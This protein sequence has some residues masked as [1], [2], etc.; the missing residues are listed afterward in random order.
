MP[1]KKSIPNAIISWISDSPGKLIVYF[2]ASLFIF[3][4]IGIIVLANK[5][6]L[7]KETFGR[8]IGNTFLHLISASGVGA[9]LTLLLAKYNHQH[10]KF[11]IDEQ[12]A[13]TQS[14]QLQELNRISNENKNQF[15][16]NIL[17]DLNETY[18]GFKSAR[19]MLRAKAFK[20]SYEDVIKNNSAIIDTKIYD[21]YLEKINDY[22]LRLETIL[23]ELDTNTNIFKNYSQIKTSINQMQEYLHGL[24]QE[25]ENYRFK[26]NA[27]S[28]SLTIEPFDKIK[29]LVDHAKK[30]GPLKIKFIYPYKKAIAAVR[31]ELLDGNKINL[32]IEQNKAT[33]RL[34]FDEVCNQGKWEI[35]NEIFA[36]QV[37]FNGKSG[38]PGIVIK[39]LQEIKD[40]FTN[41]KVK[42]NKQVAE[43]DRVSTMRTWTGIQSKEYN[44]S[45]PTNQL[46]TWMEISVVRLENGKIVE[47]WVVRSELTVASDDEKV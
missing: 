36:E 1:I 38:A 12:R 13:Y 30:N 26:A 21:H 14:I 42:V 47:D 15:V 11:K 2:L 8:E 19:R 27:D 24:V 9:I 37:N 45:P 44:N 16:K 35:I 22:Q 25:Y 43:E 33:V 34:F 46:M 39:Y 31:K 29:E 5:S 32:S 10:E 7:G 18:S 41:P 3:S 28:G 4:I 17:R 23:S 6:M 40:A 20:V